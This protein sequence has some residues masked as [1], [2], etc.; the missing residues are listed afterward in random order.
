MIF[1]LLFRERPLEQAGCPGR[2]DAESTTY[3]QRGSHMGQQ[4]DQLRLT[5]GSKDETWV[6]R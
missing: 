2:F 6:Q 3:E 5:G 1:I 4:R